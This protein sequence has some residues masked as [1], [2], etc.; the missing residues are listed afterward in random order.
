MK[1]L[2][3]LL[4]LLLINS[5][6]SIAQTNVNYYV[7]GYTD[8]VTHGTPGTIDGWYVNLQKYWFYRYRLVNDFMKIGAQAGE[9]LIA[10]KRIKGTM[11]LIKAII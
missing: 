9:S 1:N 10:E 7:D 6:Y 11:F 2:L 4:C 5:I 3:W 8:H